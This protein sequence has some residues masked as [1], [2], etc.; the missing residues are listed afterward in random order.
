MKNA[1]LAAVAGAA[2][3]QL[4]NIFVP[5]GY[6]LI[7]N[8][9]RCFLPLEKTYYDLFRRYNYETR[10]ANTEVNDLIRELEVCAD[11]GS[12]EAALRLGKIHLYGLFGRVPDCHLAEHY[13]KSAAEAGYAEAEFWMELRPEDR[14]D[15]GGEADFGMPPSQFSYDIRRISLGTASSSPR[16]CRGRA[17]GRAARG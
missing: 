5:I 10:P 7:F 16:R 17:V 3:T 2:V 8:E 11:R 12:P 15:S 6:E 14:C 1:I 9:N 4:V 13:L